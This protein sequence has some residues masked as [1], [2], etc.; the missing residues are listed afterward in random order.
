M[1]TA[2]PLRILSA[3]GVDEE[4][5]G[6]L[7]ICVAA[8]GGPRWLWLP[9]LDAVLNSFAQLG[10]GGVYEVRCTDVA[11]YCGIPSFVALSWGVDFKT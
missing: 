6:S 3:A 5:C 7:L 8:F 2:S 11:S 1:T 10:S 9:T 4:A